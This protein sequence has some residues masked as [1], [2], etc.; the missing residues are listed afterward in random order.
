[1]L[2]NLKTR[3]ER[4]LIYVRPGAGPSLGWDLRAV[5]PLTPGAAVDSMDFSCPTPDWSFLLFR[6]S[7]QELGALAPKVLDTESENSGCQEQ[8]PGD[9]EPRGM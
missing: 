3:F 9:R 7:T 6:H 5:A 4:N 8:R 2:A 1:M